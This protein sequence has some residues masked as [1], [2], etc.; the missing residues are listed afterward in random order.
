MDDAAR[1]VEEDC[2]REMRRGGDQDFAL[3]LRSRI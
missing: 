2:G 3:L 1:Y